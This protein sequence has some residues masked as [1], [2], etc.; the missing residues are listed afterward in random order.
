MRI[1]V[2]EQDASMA[3]H[4]RQGLEREDCSVDVATDGE[5]ALR[6]AGIHPY[7]VLVLEVMASSEEGFTLVR[8]LRRKGIITPVLFLTSRKEIEDRVRGLDAGADDYL[9]KPFSM[10]ELLARLRALSRRPRPQAGK[11]LRVADLELD[12]ISHQAMRAGEHIKLTRREFALLDLLMSASPRPVS[13]AAI[14]EQVWHNGLDSQSNVVNV[15]IAKLRRKLRRE[16]SPPLLHSVRGI[17]FCCRE[18]L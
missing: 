5:E 10:V 18:L 12:L 2:A 9:T 13:K 7:D 11:R 17:G 3:E 1:L 8:Q 15:Y 14:I 4:V 6:L 16:H